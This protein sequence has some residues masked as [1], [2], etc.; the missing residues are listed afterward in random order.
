MTVYE[1]IQLKEQQVE[2]LTHEIAALR[3]AAR[4]LEESQSA[5]SEPVVSLSTIGAGHASRS[6]GKSFKQFP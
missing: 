1:I 2:R 3:V 4:M 6:E 5:D